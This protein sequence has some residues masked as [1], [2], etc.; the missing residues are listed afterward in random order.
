MRGAVKRA[1]PQS[2]V[3]FFM[4]AIQPAT[5]SVDCRT[6]P[7]LRALTAFMSTLTSPALKPYSPP[8][9]AMWIAR[10]LPTRV[11]VGM[12]PTLTQVPPSSLRSM[13]AVFRPSAPRRAASAGPACPAPM[14]MASYFSAMASYFS[15]IGSLRE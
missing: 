14:T 7:S 3:T 9:R 5:P 1:W 11:L 8:R 15:I 6:T 12:Q 4:P 10:A 13:I 2:S